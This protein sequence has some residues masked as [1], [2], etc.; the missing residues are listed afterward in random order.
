[1]NDEIDFS[2]DCKTGDIQLVI[3]K[4]R[5][6]F[7]LQMEVVKDQEKLDEKIKKIRFIE[8]EELPLICENENFYDDVSLGNGYKLTLKPVVSGS[9]P[10]MSAINKEKDP[11]K[12]EELQEQR[13][14]CFEFLEN[15]NADSLISTTVKADI[16]RSE[17]SIENTKKIIDF[18]NSLGL[19]CFYEKSVHYQ[20][21]NSFIK[22][23]LN[24]EGGI[25]IPFDLFNIFVGKKATIKKI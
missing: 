21:L 11:E 25:D 14:S 8:T 10:S 6:L 17:K 22:E 18:I 12:K 2:K 13:E 24:N 15:N 23:Q 4:A 9:I 1:M 20:T 5:E 19:D 16:K 7:R 3:E